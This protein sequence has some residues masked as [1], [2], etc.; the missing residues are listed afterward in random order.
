MQFLGELDRAGDGLI[1]RGDFSTWFKAFAERS[2]RPSVRQEHP[3]TVA[4]QL[5]S[6]ADEGGATVSSYG[7][8]S[9]SHDPLG[10]YHGQP[11]GALSLSDLIDHRQLPVHQAAPSSYAD[12]QRSTGAASSEWGLVPA[13]QRQ[14]DQ[15]S[16]HE[17]PGRFAP[18]PRPVQSVPSGSLDAIVRTLLKQPERRAL[19]AYA[20]LLPIN[21]F[22]LHTPRRQR[23]RGSEYGSVS[24]SYG[25]H[26]K[27]VRYLS[28]WEAEAL[29]GS[30][31]A[32]AE[33]AVDLMSAVSKAVKS[34][35]QAVNPA[36][37]GFGED[38]G[39]GWNAEWQRL[40][41]TPEVTAPDALRKTVAIQAFLRKFL[42]I[43]EEVGKVVV[44][45]MGLPPQLRSIPPAA[46]HVCATFKALLLQYF[47]WPP[48]RG[49]SLYS[50]PRNRDLHTSRAFVPC[51]AG[52]GEGK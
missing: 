3:H 2:R 47:H 35:E 40:L 10:H 52:G 4:S 21:A 30:G 6:E 5:R 19:E 51:V 39:A 36:D 28:T 44:D 32:E 14:V 20:F 15:R 34:A 11:S 25:L 43:A 1:E 22:A 48:M 46:S 45:E 7:Q 37:E 9:R 18:V 42:S 13:E 41:E 33:A 38:Q 17:H 29:H 27:T 31:K 50:G 49:C 12:D 16:S 24:S 26:K 23:G 8:D